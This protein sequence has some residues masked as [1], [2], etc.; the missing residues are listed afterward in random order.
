MGFSSASA[1]HFV[2][3]LGIIL[4]TTNPWVQAGKLKISQ[5]E[6]RIEDTDY[7][8]SLVTIAEAETNVLDVSGQLK[9]H[10]HVDNDWTI[11]FIVLRADES[12]GEYDNILKIELPVCDFMESYYK[13][14]YEKIKDYS[15]A[16][17]PGT[18]PLPKGKYRLRD[19]P[20]NVHLLK[21]F[22]APGHYRI[23]Y[24]LNKDDSPKLYYRMEMEID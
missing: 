14:F 12:D 15:N 22:M 8:D 11:E 9:L 20:L 17:E 21:K 5:F 6:K 16:P 2:V 7:V 24:K 18:C 19:Y 4:L 23:K 3:V 13:I 1:Q 10:H